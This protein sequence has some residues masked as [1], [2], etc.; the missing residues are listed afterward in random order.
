[1]RRIGRGLKRLAPPEPNDVETWYTRTEVAK[2]LGSS[3]SSVY[4]L[5][6]KGKLHPQLDSQARHRFDPGEVRALV[7][8]TDTPGKAARARSP[9]ELEAA[10]FA[11]L[12]QGKSRKELVMSLCITADDAQQLWK[13]WKQNFEDAEAT[14][15]EDAL[16]AARA[17]RTA[18][19]KALF[20]NLNKE[21]TK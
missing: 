16:E 13:K 15:A 6:K 19:I 20:E 7:N 4:V 18:R 11:L 8:R 10:A 9:G 3:Q 14:Q 5:E 2:M 21:P 1:M 12:E 17:A